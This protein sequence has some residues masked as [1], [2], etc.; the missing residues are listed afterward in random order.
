MARV[1]LASESV[2][3]LVAAAVFFLYCYP[4]MMALE[5]PYDCMLGYWSQGSPGGK[6]QESQTAAF[7]NGSGIGFQTD[8]N[9]QRHRRILPAV[10]LPRPART[11]EASSIFDTSTENKAFSGRR[12]WNEGN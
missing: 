12:F 8:R 6:M 5:A 7:Q 9:C 10:D 4:R 11:D 1:C 2:L 3:I